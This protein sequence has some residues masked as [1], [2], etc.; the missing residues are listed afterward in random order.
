M[1]FQNL[2][3]NSIKLKNRIVVSPMCQYSSQNGSPSNW[4]YQHLEHLSSTGAS[5]VL[6]ESTAVDR[7]GKISD[8]GK[9]SKVIDEALNE[10]TLIAGQKAVVTKAKKSE[11]GFKL[12]EGYPIGARVTLRGDKMYEFLSKLVNLALPRV[13]D[14]R[15]ISNKAFDKRGNYNLGIEDHL[16]F[17]EIDPTKSTKVKGLNITIV[18]TAEDDEKSKF[19]LEKLGFPFKR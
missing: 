10:L 5:M 14:F 6:L 9:D 1:I 15:G 3:I 16:V 18:T 8:A 19:L 12:R 13:R 11:A 7:L 4:H 17:P 2:K